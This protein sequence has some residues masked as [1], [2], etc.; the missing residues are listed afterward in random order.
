MTYA[1]CPF[2]F[3]GGTDIEALLGAHGGVRL[4]NLL[5]DVLS[6]FMAD[7]SELATDVCKEVRNDLDH[8]L[9]F[10]KVVFSWSFTGP[11]KIPVQQT[12]PGNGT[13]EPQEPRGRNIASFLYGANSLL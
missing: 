3:G 2:L 9:A 10:L 13:R 8:D 12:P 5:V 4:A 1:F 11:S 6:P 7:E